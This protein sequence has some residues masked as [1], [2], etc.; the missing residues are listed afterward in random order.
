MIFSSLPKITYVDEAIMKSKEVPFAYP[1]PKMVLYSFFL[2]CQGLNKKKNSNIE[3]EI[4][5]SQRKRIKE[6]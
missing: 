3:T 1:M 5:N 6:E 4:R 2:I